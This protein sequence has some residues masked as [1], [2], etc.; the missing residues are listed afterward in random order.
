MDKNPINDVN[1]F[2]TNFNNNLNEQKTNKN[3]PE[4]QLSTFDHSS[5][6]KQNSM[7]L[8]RDFKS[9]NEKNMNNSDLTIDAFNENNKNYQTFNQ[10]DSNNQFFTHSQTFYKEPLVTQE[11]NSAQNPIQPNI[12]NENHLLV[13]TDDVIS[14]KNQKIF[15]YYCAYH[16]LVFL[17][18]IPIVVFAFGIGSKLKYSE[19]YYFNRIYQNWNKS[20][21][22]KVST[23]NCNSFSDQLLQESW[24]GTK[25]GCNCYTYIKNT[26]CGRRSSCKTISPI[27]PIPISIW[28]GSPL[29]RQTN[30]YWANKTYLDLTIEKSA[31]FCGTGLRSCGII[32]SIGNHLCVESSISCPVISLGIYDKLAFDKIKENLPKENNIVNLKNGILVYSN[33][34]KNYTDINK[35]KI[36]I[37]FK[38]SNN[39]PCMNPYFENIGFSIYQLDIY[40]QRQQCL[41]YTNDNDNLLVDPDGMKKTYFFNNNYLEIDRVFQEML[42]TE[43]GITQ[44]TYNLPLFPKEQYNHDISLYSQNYFGINVQCLKEIKRNG[45]GKELIEDLKTISNISSISF[46]GMTIF[47]ILVA[48]FILMILFNGTSIVSK[49]KKTHKPFRV[50]RLSAFLYIGFALALIIFLFVLIGFFAGVKGKVGLGENFQQIFGFPR[51]V[52]QYTIDLYQQL[53]PDLLTVRSNINWA[54]FLSLFEIVMISIFGCYSLWYTKN[55]V[56]VYS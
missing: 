38:I 13:L 19:S 45:I 39:Q 7:I 37:D 48:C 56:E 30:S 55:E 32:D 28:R 44:K 43:N 3:N 35:V 41:K 22:S 27:N 26:G 34:P 42:Y 1:C 54:I 40:S 17:I 18:G 33:D 9:I 52:D 50:D 12:A 4:I 11:I 10:Q 15:N 24:A 6:E 2:N 23:D 14:E 5:F 51:C 49:S 47:A 53:V 16:F 29:C 8:D 25:A 46:T 31:D 20:P 21:Y 36:P